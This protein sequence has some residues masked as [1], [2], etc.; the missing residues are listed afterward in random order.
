LARILHSNL[1]MNMDRRVYRHIVM[2]TNKEDKV[3]RQIDRV[4]KALADGHVQN[5]QSD[6]DKLVY[7]QED[8]Q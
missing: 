5:R 2:Q 7:I 4:W 1:I 8:M 3:D 6:M